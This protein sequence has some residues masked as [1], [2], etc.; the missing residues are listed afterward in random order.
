MAVSCLDE[1]Q[2]TLEFPD[3]SV[4]SG[5]THVRE[6]S[7]KQN[8]CLGFDPHWREW[9]LSLESQYLSVDVRGCG[10]RTFKFDGEA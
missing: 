9:T 8:P 10:A 3:G 7:T 6:L 2:V 4:V 1:V 5:K